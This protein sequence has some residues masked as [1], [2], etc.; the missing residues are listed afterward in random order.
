MLAGRLVYLHTHTL[1]ED[2]D[3]TEVTV[4][5]FD[6]SDASMI[7]EML[8]AVRAHDVRRVDK[9]K[10]ATSADAARQ[11][12]A[13]YEATDDISQRVLLQFLLFSSGHLELARPVFADI[14]GLVGTMLHGG[15]STDGTT[16]DPRFDLSVAISGLERDRD[17]FG[18]YM[19]DEEAFVS[20]LAR[21]SPAAAR[22]A[23][24]GAL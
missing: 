5:Q 13:A 1:I 18:V 22:R 11:L 19:S 10:Q 2:G 17:R 16:V 20:A 14:V 3:A 8:A 9:A 24:R 4:R 12:I 21:H 15:A 23:D 7:E 6:I